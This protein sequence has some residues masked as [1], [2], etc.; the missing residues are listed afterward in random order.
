MLRHAQ[1]SF[2]H[3]ADYSFI[4]YA[5]K[6]RWVQFK[7]LSDEFDRFIP[8]N[9]SD[10]SEEREAELIRLRAIN[11]KIPDSEIVRMI[12]QQIKGRAVPEIQV[13]LKFADRVMSEYVTVTFLAHALAES[14]INALLAVGLG[15]GGAAEVFVLLE[16]ADIKEKWLAGPKSF[17]PAY[18]LSKDGAIYETLQ[19]LTRQRNALVHYKIE[20]EIEGKRVVD[21][22]RLDRASLKDHIAWIKRYFSLPYDLASHVRRQIPELPFTMLFDAGPI[23]RFA[24]HAGG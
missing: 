3:T 19:H 22:S 6:A 17:H 1:L 24:P 18:H 11:P 9:I 13:Y 16:R 14:A 4:D 23:S 7:D 8:R 10:Y 15:I 21:G 12:E 2:S 20:L 5:L